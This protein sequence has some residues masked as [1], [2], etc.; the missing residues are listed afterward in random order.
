M[1]A[2][3]VLGIVVAVFGFAKSAKSDCPADTAL[4]WT[5]PSDGDVDVPTDTLIWVRHIGI[6]PSTS[7]LTIDGVEV[8]RSADIDWA[9]VPTLAPNTTYTAHFVGQAFNLASPIEATITF[10]TGS[11]EEPT[12]AE[13]VI[14]GHEILDRANTETWDACRRADLTGCYDQG[15]DALM[16]LD[17]EGAKPFL[18]STGGAYAGE[19]SRAACSPP[20]FV[21]IRSVFENSDG[22]VVVDAIAR[23]GA[24]ASSTPYCPNAEA[25]DAGPDLGDAGDDG[26]AGE[27]SC[28]CVAASSDGAF[29]WCLVA[30]VALGLRRRRAQRA[31]G[32]P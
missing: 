13:P 32:S 9:Y 29:A 4:W 30:G 27:L 26:G 6:D 23:S 7:M 17:V 28:T 15:E 10:T 3:I 11:D 21:G 16:V 12:L 25:A 20:T 22:C 31:C 14:V 1:R 5:S 19:L 8:S 18:W 24:V 2:G